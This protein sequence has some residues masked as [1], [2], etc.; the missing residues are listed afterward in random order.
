MSCDTTTVI[1]GE[2]DCGPINHDSNC[3]AL[4]EHSIKADLNYSTDLKPCTLVHRILYPPIHSKL[5]SDGQAI[6]YPTLGRTI[7]TGLLQ[8]TTKRM[9]SKYRIL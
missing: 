4:S 3:G 2:A 5:I 1:A 7:L 8:K 9:L 6:I